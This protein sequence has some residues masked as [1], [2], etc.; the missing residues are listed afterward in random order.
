M[1]HAVKDVAYGAAA[2]VAH[3]LLP[4]MYLANIELSR[5]L[6]LLFSRLDITCVLDV[7]ANDGQ[8]RNFLRRRCGYRGFI[9]SY[10]PVGEVFERIE[11]RAR[12]D[13]RWI[14]ENCALGAED[15]HAPFN[16][17]HDTHFSSFL[18]PIVPDVDQPDLVDGNTIVRTDLV[19]VRTLETALD[20]LPSRLAQ[21][22]IY[23]KLDTQGYDLTILRSAGE[24]LSRIAALQLELSVKA[25]YD[26]APGFADGVAALADFGFELTGLFPV[27]RDRQLRVIEFDATAVRSD[28]TS[29]ND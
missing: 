17:M 25:I 4:A 2:E 23:L 7:G 10:E 20:R 5:H 28:R 1:A 6:R 13:R 3:R 22:G 27:T 19:E 11:A 12:R 29:P 21:G 16:V 8:F 18:R 26:Q 15:S 24:S 9:V 14:V